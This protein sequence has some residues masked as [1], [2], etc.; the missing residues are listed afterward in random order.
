MGIFLFQVVMEA[1]GAMDGQMMSPARPEEEMAK[2]EDQLKVVC[3]LLIFKNFLSVLIQPQTVIGDVSLY[4]H[5]SLI[6]ISI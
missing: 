2:D 4:P 3:L 1:D 5:Q 6:F